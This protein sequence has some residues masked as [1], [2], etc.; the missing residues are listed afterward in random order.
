MIIFETPRLLVRRYN[1]ADVENF[2]LLNSNPDV[3]RYIRQ[4]KTF[5]ESRNFLLDNIAFYEKHPLFGRLAV[6]EKDTGNFA[7]SFAIIPL[8][9]T[10]FWQVGYALMKPYWGKGYATELVKE[11]LQY[12]FTK[13][14]L[15]Y[16]A[17]VTEIMNFDSQKVLVKAGF[18]HEKNYVENG[19]ELMLFSLTSPTSAGI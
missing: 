18:T 12:S 15:T 6:N 2:Y 14:G 7:G 9:H 8:D 16:I 11:G 3:M 10:N 17:G 13:G 4:P 19:K 5:E 1:E